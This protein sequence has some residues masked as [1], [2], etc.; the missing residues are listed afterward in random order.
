MAKAHWRISS[1]GSTTVVGGVGVGVGI[2][3]VAVFYSR[4]CSGTTKLNLRG[5][6]RPW[7]GDWSGG[8]EGSLDTGDVVALVQV[9]VHLTVDSM[10]VGIRI[11]RSKGCPCLTVGVDAEH[12]MVAVEWRYE[13]RHRAVRA[14]HDTYKSPLGKGTVLYARTL[15]KDQRYID[16]G[17]R[18]FQIW[19][20]EFTEECERKRSPRD[21]REVCREWVGK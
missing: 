9:V 17:Y 18:L 11:G 3:T 19:G 6:L 21:V 12:A 5:A 1:G 8:R 4:N 2:L 16:A 14:R 20:H 10:T 7:G 13:R 15:E